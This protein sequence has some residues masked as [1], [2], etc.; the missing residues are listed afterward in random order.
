M[1]TI[2]VIAKRELKGY[3]TSPVAYVFIVIF[4]VLS[5]FFTFNVSGFYESGQADLRPFFVWHPWLFLFL[6]PSVAMRLWAEERRSGTL[7]IL[8]TL[9][10]TVGQAVVA[11]FL[12]A[13]V[14]IGI[15]LALTFPLVWTVLYLGDPDVGMIMAGYLGSFLLAG[16]YLAVGSFSSALSRSQ[17]IGFIIAVVLC[18][19]FVLA[20]WPP[21]TSALSQWAPDSVVRLVANLGFMPHYDAIQ[22]GV[23]DS[24]DLLYYV[25]FIVFM[26]VANAALLN[27]RRTS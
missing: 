7:E 21:V 13:W 10:V 18:L 17:V 14:F 26:L 15:A 16:A 20:G 12:A 27:L 22:R 19:F 23:I 25:S 3:F 24:R 4:L 8:L 11:K 6:I 2:Y 1:H 5:G 9:P